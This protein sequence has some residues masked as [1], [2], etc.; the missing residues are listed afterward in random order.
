MLGLWSR[1]SAQFQPEP[2]SAEL[3]A[4]ENDATAKFA[5]LSRPVEDESSRYS[6][7]PLK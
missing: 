5:G 1:V 6:L 3:C 7:I 2:E 4:A